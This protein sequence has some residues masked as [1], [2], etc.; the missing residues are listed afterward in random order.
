MVVQMTGTPQADG[1]GHGQGL[2][3]EGTKNKR[4]TKEIFHTESIG[5]KTR[6][7]EI[8]EIKIITGQEIGEI[9]SLTRKRNGLHLGTMTEMIVKDNLKTGIT[10]PPETK[11]IMYQMMIN[12]M[13]STTGG[14]M[15]IPA[16]EKIW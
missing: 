6:G 12:A 15:K 11:I 16:N 13:I 2:M 4:E 10:L 7:Q 9:L 1:Q 8:I 14:M 3:N 5:G